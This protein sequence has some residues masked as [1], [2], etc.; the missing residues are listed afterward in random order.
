[1]PHLVVA[2]MQVGELLQS[3]NVDL[4]DLSA[5]NHSY[6]DYG[7][8]VLVEINYVNFKPWIGVLCVMCLFSYFT[9]PAGSCFS[10][11]VH[12]VQHFA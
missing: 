12:K 7:C 9:F 2:Q 10:T 5:A 11:V 3:G 1:M 4:G 8:V 6:R